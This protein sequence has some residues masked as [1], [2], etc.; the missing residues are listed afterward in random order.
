MI[1]KLN[2]R[3]P[4]TKTSPRPQK[5]TRFSLFISLS[6]SLSAPPQKAHDAGTTYTD[7]IAALA[8]V[9][10]TTWL[11]QCTAP[12]IDVIGEKSTTCTSPRNLGSRTICRAVPAWTEMI[13]EFPRL[14]TLQP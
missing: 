4:K 7:H 1:T 11:E 10:L 5:K 2:I 3:K 6:P 8:G 12:Y 14:R 9:L 13:L